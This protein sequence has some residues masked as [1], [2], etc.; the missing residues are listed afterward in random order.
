LRLE[1]ASLVN[2]VA[3]NEISKPPFREFNWLQ[4]DIE[5]DRRTD[6]SVI[7][8]SR[9][10]L[11]AY[12]TH[13]P[14]YLARHATENPDRIWLA[15]RRGPERQWSKVTFAEGKRVVDSLTQGLLDLR[16]DHDR[17]LAILSGNSL[18]HAFITL[19][20][21]Q[22]RILVAPLSP[23]Y[24]LLS[25]DHGKL[26]SIFSLLR[27]GA[28]FVQDGVAFEKALQALDLKDAPI[29]CADRPP[30]SLTS[31]PFSEL[32]SAR[33]TSAVE[34]SIA[35]ITGDTTAK[36]ML[37]SGS[38]GMPKVV[39][40]TQRMMCANVTMGM[41]T[42]I[43]DPEQPP[44]VRLDWMPWSHAMAGNATFNTVLAYGSA[45][46]LDEGRPIPG[47]FDET[48]RNLRDVSP[49]VCAS[50]PVGYAMLAAALE[51]DD[52]LRDSFFKRMEVLAY[53]GGR[54]PDDL[55]ERMQALSV[56]S[57]GRRIVFTSGWGATETTALSTS[58]Y[59]DN[60][61]PGLIGLPPPG[62][63]LKMVPQVD[64]KYELRLRGVTVTPGYYRQ[65]ELTRAAFDE[66]G[67]YRIG[68]L[69]AFVDEK[70]PSQGLLFAGRIAEEFKLLTGTFVPVGA[71]RVEVIAAASPVIQDAL[72]TGQ[73]RPFVGILA[74]PALEACRRLIGN[75][76]AAPETVV[77]HPL[78]RDHV[79]DRLRA[80]NREFAGS[81]S[82]RI[83]RAILM[84][85]PAS[86]DSGE[87]TDKGYINQRAG[88][89][90]RSAFVVR[91]YAEAP[92]DDV[93]VVE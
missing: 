52:G 77:A 86:I 50:A 3:D 83:A 75:M 38:T 6:G 51:S 61:R 82:M 25:R 70:D 7:I 17:P 92:D 78:V 89:E 54:L 64:G 48:I 73:D 5:A 71:L 39:I 65:P 68:D 19:A 11:G 34:D 66:E 18:E 80:H 53:G 55:Y 26:K 63:E 60:E 88:L 93:I 49:T 28:V 90:R 45:L 13:I 57:T 20:C 79:R 56:R 16:L 40:N 91:L 1:E 8:R 84:A 22:A 4:R 46:Y 59:W 43:R 44:A 85:E 9:I 10:P 32:A 33:P 2:F 35:K 67:F 72:V 87:L 81:T 31:V 42:F 30:T 21:M 15:Q 76:S 27:P 62:I 69:G 74:W 14:V 41:Q 23:A 12:E 47:M 58:T 24:S 36:L 29:V 37:T